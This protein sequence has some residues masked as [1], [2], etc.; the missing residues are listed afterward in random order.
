[1]ARMVRRPSADGISLDYFGLLVPGFILWA[2]YGL[3]SG[4]LFA[5]VP[6][7]VA[8]VT[9]VCVIALTI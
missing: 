4:D 3:I 5:A 1:M 7:L 9:A 8:T 6:N 2:G